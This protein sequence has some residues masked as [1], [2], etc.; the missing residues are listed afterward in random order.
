[1]VLLLS[2]VALPAWA[3]DEVT[4]YRCVDASGHLTLRDTPC[5]RNQKQQARTM[6]RPRDSRAPIP[7]PAPAPAQRELPVGRLAMAIAPRPM[8]ECIPPDGEPYLSDSDAGRPRFVP[9]WTL[10]YPVFLPTG[11][12]RNPVMSGNAT[13]L[14]V[15]PDATSTRGLRRRPLLPGAYAG[16]GTWVRDDCYALPQAD[17]CARLAD[18]RDAIRTRFFNAMPSEREVLGVEE[19]QINARLDNDCG[20]H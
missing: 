14:V 2:C 4:I 8:Y 13:G 19:R 7:A 9:L 20:R 1:M 18:R 11:L 15:L 17:V 10:D 6:L 5:A 16:A 3:A 12:E